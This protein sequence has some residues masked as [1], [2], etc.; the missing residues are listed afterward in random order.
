MPRNPA[1]SRQK[2]LW[3]A[4][5]ITAI[6]AG[7]FH[8]AE[9]R[10]TGTSIFLRRIST[11]ARRH[12]DSSPNYSKIEDGLWMGGYVYEPP[13]GTQAVLNLCESKDLYEVKSSKMETIP[14]GPPAPS[15]EWLGR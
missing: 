10:S 13:A 8:F 3:I 14:D 6:C 15:I 7:T 9:Y 1:K 2:K 12:F 11:T 4:F 5:A